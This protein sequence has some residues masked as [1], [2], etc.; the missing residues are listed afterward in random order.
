MNENKGLA[1]DERKED[2]VD[3]AELGKTEE[4]NESREH[5]PVLDELSPTSLLLCMRSRHD[6]Q[7]A[8]KLESPKLTD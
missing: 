8:A 3:H 7:S 1:D 5:Q 4:K 6:G 2:F